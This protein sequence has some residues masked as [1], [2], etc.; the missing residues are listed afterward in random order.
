MSLICYQCDD[1]FYRVVNGDA[2]SVH[3][4]VCGEWFCSQTCLELHEEAMK[5]HG[6]IVDETGDSFSFT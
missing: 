1:D 5:V 6:R 2:N 3:C 4:D